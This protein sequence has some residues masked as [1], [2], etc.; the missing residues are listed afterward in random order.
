MNQ[1]ILFLLLIIHD[2]LILWL[3]FKILV[4]YESHIK[5]LLYI[6][7]QSLH[8]KVMVYE[9]NSIQKLFNELNLN[10][11]HQSSH[12]GKYYINTILLLK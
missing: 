5:F 2:P 6:I 9:E 10:V 11:N 3:F 4:F 8:H 12:K 7:I 1:Q